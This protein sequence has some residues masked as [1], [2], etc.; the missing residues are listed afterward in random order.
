[1]TVGDVTAEA[2]AARLTARLARE[3]RIPAESIEPE[4]DLFSYGLDSLTAITLLGE[5][6]DWLGMELDP[7]M[8]WDHPSIGALSSHIAGLAART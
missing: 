5:I 4:A 1:M 7:A 8:I 2:V 3:L 6:E